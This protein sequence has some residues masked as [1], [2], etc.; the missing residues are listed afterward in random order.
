M[1]VFGLI[2]H[3]VDLDGWAHLNGNR[4]CEVTLRVY[5]LSVDGDCCT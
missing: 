2:K 1:L 4:A 5:T 3:A